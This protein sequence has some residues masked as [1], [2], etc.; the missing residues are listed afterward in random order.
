MTGTR[1]DRPNLLPQDGEVY[2]YPDFFSQQESD[3]FFAALLKEVSWKQEPI[4]LFGKKVMQ[5]RFTAW[6]G[7]ESYSY[8]GTKMSPQK[9]TPTLQK[10]KNKI[11]KEFGI[12]FN[13]AL[14]NQYRNE[15]DSMGWHRDNEKE[16]GSNPVICSVSL[17]ATRD[18]KFKHAQNKDLKTAAPLSPGSV[19]FMQGATQH[20][21]LHA[22]P[23]R[24]KACDARIN[25]TFRQ[26]KK[27]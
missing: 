8:S 20:H 14:L 19:L 25:I 24:T 12:I 27:V 2:F 26:I 17:G 10:I 3:L 6:Y 23:K 1:K 16:L 13:S 22:L 21:W 7:D 4:V 15:Q 9:W 11:E 18:F 5:P